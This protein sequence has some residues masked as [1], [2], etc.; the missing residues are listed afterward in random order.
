MT[1]REPVPP[2]PRVGRRPLA[3][4]PVEVATAYDLVVAGESAISREALRAV[5]RSP[6]TVRTAVLASE[7]LGPPR[8]L[9]PHGAPGTFGTT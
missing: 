2:V 5:L 4:Q 1:L 3:E 7:I 9:R 8:A 6:A